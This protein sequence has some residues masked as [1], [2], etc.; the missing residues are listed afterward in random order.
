MAPQLRILYWNLSCSKNGISHEW[1]NMF[2]RRNTGYPVIRPQSVNND[3]EFRGIMRIWQQVLF[4]AKEMQ[5]LFLNTLQTGNA[6]MNFSLL[7]VVD[8]SRINTFLEHDKLQHTIHRS[9]ATQLPWSCAIRLLNICFVFSN[10]TSLFFK[11]L[12]VFLTSCKGE[13]FAVFKLYVSARS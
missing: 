13:C 5:L 11:S 6:L 7:N 4:T 1:S 3:V 9:G 2:K 10:M 8:R 12:P